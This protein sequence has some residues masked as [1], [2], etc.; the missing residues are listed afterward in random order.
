MT[1]DYRAWHRQRI[2][3]ER[4]SDP[5]REIDALLGLTKHRHRDS[6]PTM[7]PFQ[8]KQL[9]YLVWLMGRESFAPRGGRARRLMF[10]CRCYLCDVK[11]EVRGAVRA[12]AFVAILHRRHST[13]VMW[14]AWE[15]PE[16]PQTVW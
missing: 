16:Y 3:D 14:R 5:H 7:H 15:Q 2:R 11:I 13:F 1:G 12:F 10:L 4:D 6:W 9:R 8:V